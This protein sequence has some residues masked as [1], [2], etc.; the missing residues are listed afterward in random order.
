MNGHLPRGHAPKQRDN[1]DL[2][3]SGEP[4][5]LRTLFAPSQGEEAIS[6]LFP[7][8]T[9]WDRQESTGD[10]PCDNILIFDTDASHADTLAKAL[11]LVGFQASVVGTREA[12]IAAVK[13]GG[14]DLVI[15]VP[16]SPSWWRSDLKSFCKAI[17]DVA[18]RPET[19]CVLRWLPNGPSDRLYGDE[20]NIE[21]LHER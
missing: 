17:R 1:R 5:N 9:L 6:D 4:A 7:P 2:I 20:L 11:T 18:D 8:E 13:Q 21:V 10:A 12:V 19:V 14:V 16:R 15:I 3:P